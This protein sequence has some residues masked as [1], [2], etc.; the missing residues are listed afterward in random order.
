MRG[1]R[2]SFY[3]MTA[4]LAAVV[5]LAVDLFHYDRGASQ[6]DI[7]TL[8]R[9]TRN[10][11]GL[12]RRYQRQ[13]STWGKVVYPP[14]APRIVSNFHVRRWRGM[15]HQGIDI[16]GLP[17]QPII[18]VADGQVIE[19]YTSKCAGP[20]VVIDHGRDKNG[21]PLIAQ[22]VHVQDI[23]VEERQAVSRGDMVARLGD[24]YSQFECIGGSPHLHLEL[25]RTRRNGNKGINPHLLWADGPYHITC[26]DENRNYP[27][28]T[29]T[30]PMP[31]AGTPDSP[32]SDWYPGKNSSR[33]LRDA[34]P[35]PADRPE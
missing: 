23:L 17:G 27:T 32:R 18:A 28:G 30:Y 6:G 16:W 10:Q 31:C 2:V 9:D 33:R 1:R 8:Q 25:L 35:T 3:L 24:N 14:G 13:D 4:F 15:I 21:K 22:Y 34:L 5:V 12:A 26:F 20:I 11:Q 7:N 19:T 29:L